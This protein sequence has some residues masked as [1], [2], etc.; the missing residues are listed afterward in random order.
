MESVPPRN[1]PSRIPRID[2]ASE[3]EQLR[4]ISGQVESAA[5]EKLS[6]LR[7]ERPGQKAVMP[8]KLD[9][10]PGTA[11]TEVERL[12]REA[13]QLDAQT[14]RD[15][16]AWFAAHLA[17]MSP[18]DYA[19]ELSRLSK[20]LPQRK[21]VSSIR[22]EASGDDAKIRAEIERELHRLLVSAQ[23][24]LAQIQCSSGSR[25]LDAAE[26]ARRRENYS[27]MQR[28]ALYRAQSRIATY[29]KE[30]SCY[31]GRG[32]YSGEIPAMMPLAPD[33][34]AESFPNIPSPKNAHALG[35]RRFKASGRAGPWAY[36]DSWYSV[37]PFPN[38]ARTMIDAVFPP[39]EMFD[40]DATYLGE[41][42]REFRWEFL[43]ASQPE[44]TPPGLE[45]FTICYLYTEV[46]FDEPREVWV[47]IG[48][49][50][51]SRVWLNDELIFQ[52]SNELKAMQRDEA[53]RRVTFEK[54]YNRISIRLENAI[55]GGGFLFLIHT[56]T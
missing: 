12:Y 15:S 4:G 16:L 55:G 18:L 8:T 34:A 28:V 23:T 48:S 35:G 33:A 29:G 19:E 38:P 26:R 43:K 53:Y 14:Q 22:R 30:R 3:L 45:K 32:Q 10:L 39:E 54:G 44:I 49:D 1:E 6:E 20:A 51:K 46:W 41:K 40:L 42:G 17:L 7:V 24:R 25:G 27:A 52:S 5:R 21:T 2:L 56:G 31:L 36:L 37:G 47:A 9:T 50:D 11:K 13:L